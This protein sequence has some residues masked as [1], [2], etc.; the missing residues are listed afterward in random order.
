[1]RDM[2]KNSLL[3][4]LGITAV[5]RKRILNI[6]NTLKTKGEEFKNENAIIKRHWEKFEIISERFE[7][8][9]YRL[10]ER[11]NI[12][13]KSELSE[14]SEKIERLLKQRVSRQ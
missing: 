11:L 13:T 14:L 10:I 5:G 1:M 9:T 4:G 6:Y 3:V 2:L 12:A 8:M 7:K